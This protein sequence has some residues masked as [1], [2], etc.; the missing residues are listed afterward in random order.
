[1]VQKMCAA[2]MDGFSAHVNMMR[3]MRADGMHKS[4]L[5]KLFVDYDQ[6]SFSLCTKKYHITELLTRGVTVRDFLLSGA[7]W[8]TL[9]ALGYRICDM[10]ALGGTMDDIVSMGVHI[11]H[12]VDE[13]D[14]ATPSFILPLLRNK[15]ELTQWTP[16]ELFKMGFTFDQLLDVGL[17]QTDYT[18]NEMSYFYKPSVSQKMRWASGVSSAPVTPTPVPVQHRDL[19]K[20]KIDVSNLRVS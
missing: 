19:S 17:N 10:K 18:M 20:I 7:S 4:W 2:S 15:S 11:S 3:S 8:N 13:H 12:L 1:M 6:R 5:K 14:H 9:R 16:A